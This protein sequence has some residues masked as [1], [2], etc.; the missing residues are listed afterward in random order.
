MVSF[1]EIQIF[2]S[3]SHS[4]IKNPCF[5]DL[6]NVGIN[7]CF[8]IMTF[9]L[10]IWRQCKVDSNLEKAM[11]DQIV[12]SMRYRFHNARWFTL[13][14]L[15]L[16][17]LTKVTESLWSE[18]LFEKFPERLNV[19]MTPSMSL[20]YLCQR[21]RTKLEKVDE[22]TGIQ[23]VH[24]KSTF[25]SKATFSWILP[26]LKLG[27]ERPLELTDLGNLPQMKS[28]LQPQVESLEKELA[29]HQYQKF[30]DAFKTEKLKAK[31]ENRSLSL[32]RVYIK[33]FWPEM[34]VAG[35]F[36][37]LA[38]F[39]AYVGPL[40]IGIIINYV[41]NVEDNQT[42][43][44][45]NMHFIST[46]QF[47]SN[48]YVMCVLV[49]LAT[50]VQ[51]TTSQTFM[52]MVIMEGIHLRSAMQGLIYS[53]SLKIPA[54]NNVDTGAIVNYISTDSFNLLN[55]FSMGHYVWAIPLK[56]IVL[57][58]LLYLYLGFSALVGAGSII[59]IAPLQ[60]YIVK[61]MKVLQDESFKVGDERLK[62][63]NE[64][65]QGIKL[66]KLYGW[67]YSFFKNVQGYREKEVKVLQKDAICKALNTSL[68]QA[69][70]ILVALLTFAIFSLIE[71]RPLTPADAFTG[72]ALFNQL[73][74]PLFIFPIVIPIAISAVI[75]TRRLEEFL[76]LS[77]VHSFFPSEEEKH[78]ETVEYQPVSNEIPMV[79]L[80]QP[81]MDETVITTM[82]A[83]TEE[84]EDDSDGVFLPDESHETKNGS[85]QNHNEFVSVEK[86]SDDFL[87]TVTVHDGTFKWSYSDSLPVLQNINITVP[88][89]KLTMI[90]GSIGSGKSS[91]LAALMGE[92]YTDQGR[93][94][95]FLENEVAFA[96]QKPWL[97]NAS[98]KDNI[99]FGKPYYHKRYQNV[100]QACALKPDIDLLPN[101]DQTEIGEKGINLSGGQKQRIALARAFY[102]KARTVILDDPL[103][104]L[105]AQVGAHVF[106]HG[107]TKILLK[108]RRTVIL[109]THKLQFLPKA[110]MIIVLE[111]GKVK[112]SGSYSDIEHQ[113]SALC[114]IWRAK[115]K[116]EE[117][118]NKSPVSGEKTA[119]ERR[120]LFR[121]FSKQSLVKMSSVQDVRP[122]RMRLMSLSR[123]MSHDPSSPIP[124]QE[125]GEESERT[126]HPLTR[127]FSGRIARFSQRPTFMREES[128]ISTLSDDVWVE[129]DQEG[130]DEINGGLISE[131]ERQRGKIS[132]KVYL[133]YMKACGYL[134]SMFLLFIMTSTQTIKVYT[135][136]WLSE[137]ASLSSYNQSVADDTTSDLGL[138]VVNGSRST[139]KF[140]DS[141][142]LLFYLILFRRF[143]ETTPL[144]RIINRFSSDISVV[145]KKLPATLPMLV[146]FVLLCISAIIVDSIVTPFFLIIVIPLVLVYYFI[147][148]FFRSTSRELQRLDSITKSP[149]YSHF[150]ETLGGLAVIRAYRDEKRFSEKILKQININNAAFI[151]VN[152]ANRWLAVTLDYLGGCILFIASIGAIIA[153]NLGHVTPAFVGLA[154][155]YTLLVPIYLNWVV[156]NLSEVEM[157]MNAVERIKS[158]SNLNEEK[159]LPEP[160][161][162]SKI[163]NKW[164]ENGKIVF[165]K[166]SVRYHSSLEG[167]LKKVSFSI[168][169]GEKVGICGRTGSGKS[170]LAMGLFRM[171]DIFEGKILIDDVDIE[172][173]P[174]RTLRSRLSIIP[175]DVVLFSGTVRQNLDPES[176]HT[177]EELWES[178]KRSQLKE[179]VSILSGKL[180]GEVTEEG[181]NFSVGQR[182]LFCLARA[183]LRNSSVIMMDEATA[184]LD[185]KTDQSVQ[186][187][188]S[189]VFKGRTILTIAVSNLKLLYYF[190]LPL[191]NVVPE[192]RISSIINYDKIIVLDAGEIAEF[193]SPAELL[194]NRIG[195]FTSLVEADS[196]KA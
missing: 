175:Q 50:F 114:A 35:I 31:S 9:I 171:V 33:V 80:K 89:G 139:L 34:L 95:W 180:D 189:E 142:Y 36:K 10:L 19:I 167:V 170:S 109:V 64:L 99:L 105:D 101:G 172:T 7:A 68:T 70:S 141:Y 28:A 155:A 45:Y 14:I 85:V 2:N 57:L 44:T 126:H 148:K 127:L 69:S 125:F 185:E 18:L 195:I 106:S 37:F 92:L 12:P 136:F 111:N 112:R 11:K 71:G 47:F 124:C 168:K 87:S 116:L 22:S 1:C 191:L 102:T 13:I 152:S 75:S 169:P 39:S 157:Q 110:K 108:K 62:K 151:L 60:Y 137:W 6:I 159:Y 65:L 164:P 100:I 173:V 51:S 84:A 129:D 179:V 143:F 49:L 59:I 134:M 94:E 97:I 76:N 128:T 86:S 26:L 25:L 56:V 133:S 163:S 145:D 3:S 103:S 113:D 5:G 165:E 83:L 166:V 131:E 186:K 96:P 196:H 132:K 48:G 43:S 117:Q 38:D 82:E 74:V 193:G 150:S 72:V 20:K 17:N 177:D 98:L 160:G 27:F 161:Q 149:I 174:L 138:N 15:V 52:H 30:N 42:F 188:I 73:T 24:N 122:P 23:Y 187:I 61:K 140:A 144:G 104:A 123:Q 79:E 156:R 46:K 107:I 115:I 32:W 16:V 192:H 181:N 8:M 190:S 40:A 88:S 118:E 77:E 67:E 58:L 41:Q 176:Q 178:L 146:R 93:V 21:N 135:D 91:I 29:E 53:K 182:Q 81:N 119:S 55:F 121:M 120:T 78:E 66:L 154:M 183:I 4:L 130:D 153:A 63:T 90:V 194:Q 162:E 54:G 147:Q 158:Y 184:S